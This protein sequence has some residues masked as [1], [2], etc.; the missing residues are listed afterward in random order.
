MI[1]T[2]RLSL[3][4]QLWT[5]AACCLVLAATTVAFNLLFLFIPAG[6]APEFG[7]A[8]GVGAAY[9][10][11][12]PLPALTLTPAGLRRASLVLLAMM[13]TAYLVAACLVVVTARDDSGDRRVMRL[14][15]AGGAV[16]SL[17]LI[18]TPPSLS[19]DLYHYAL[20]GRMVI[21]RG[22][23]PY[24]TP[25]SVLAGDPLWAL[26]SWRDVPTHYGPVFTW[27]SVAAAWAGAGSPFGTAVAFKTLATAFGGLAA[28]AA[29][30]MARQERR[31]VVL[32]LM[33]IAWN[34]V[35]LVE[36]AGSGHNEMVMMGLALA[37]LCLMTGRRPAL[38]FVLLVCSVHVKWVSACVLGLALIARLRD[39]DGAGARAK[40]LARLT[41]IAVG[42]TIVL[43]LPFWAG[44]ETGATVRRLL[45]ASRDPSGAKTFHLASLLI[46]GSLVLLAI[47]LVAKHGGRFVLD[48]SAAVS[49]AFVAL[50]FNWLFPW[51]LLPAV[52]LLSASR[53]SLVS[54]LGLVA[55]TTCSIYL[56]AHW[57]VLGPYLR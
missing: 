39:L 49:L 7:F 29:A 17:A 57:S 26:A 3:R 35:A 5:L 27:L 2:I 36:T 37:G 13:W 52:V 28:W 43:Y 6:W 53:L 12:L 18:L 31:N 32:P 40:E 16:A 24:I 25:G 54:G 23:N 45:L 48:M 34:P 55:V 22:L 38:G 20:F 9:A 15:A 10:R 44:G 14:V 41:A 51:Y 47:G 19:P 30:T 1:P 33:L 56:M 42:V 21:T 46:F 4:A 11:F 8:P 50:L